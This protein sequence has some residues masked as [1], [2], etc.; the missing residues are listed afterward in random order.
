M[1]NNIRIYQ[2]LITILVL[3]IMACS[4]PSLIGNKPPAGEE[5]LFENEPDYA[6]EQEP[7][8][9]PQ[10]PEMND[11]EAIKQALLTELGA[12]ETEMEITIGKINEKFADGSVI[13]V[14]AMAGG[15]YWLAAKN[16]N[17]QWVI[18]HHGQDLPL[19]PD[20]NAY[21]FPADWVA[22][23]WDKASETAIER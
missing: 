2:L 20:V 5:E 9:P 12:Q 13:D 22:Y 3:S 14:G 1:K 6:E 15:A 7:E 16:N 4:L 18:V 23:C 21:D 10:E 11:E 19:C 8:E 17:E